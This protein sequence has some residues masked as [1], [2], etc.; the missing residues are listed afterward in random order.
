V[1]NA[2]LQEIRH[3]LASLPPANWTPVAQHQLN[4]TVLACGPERANEDDAVRDAFFIADAP[5]NIAMLV[6][7][8]ERLRAQLDA[9]PVDAIRSAI[10]SELNDCWCDAS[11]TEWLDGLEVPNDK[12]SYQ[13]KDETATA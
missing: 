10:E 9:V 8:V 1:T 7:E 4:G 6:A 5:K 2:E 12:G 13:R 3:E 11:V